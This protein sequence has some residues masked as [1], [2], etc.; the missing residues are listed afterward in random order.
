MTQNCSDCQSLYGAGNYEEVI[1]K[2]SIQQSKVGMEDLLLLAKS[3]HQLGNKKDA[4]DAYNYILTEDDKNV[5]ALIAVGALFIDLEKYDNAQ[6]AMERALKFEPKNKMANYNIAVI[7]FFKKENEKLQKFVEE[8]LKEDKNDAEFIYIKGV[9]EL[10]ANNFE[11]ALKHFEVLD[12]LDSKLENYTFY[13][14]YALMKSKDLEKAIEKFKSSIAK[15]DPQTV[16]SYYYLAQIYKE[17]ENKMEACEA[18]TNAIN[19]G[20]LTLR[21]EA[22]KYCNAKKAKNDKIKDRGVRLS[23]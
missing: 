14:A 15:N 2:I 12:K 22:D 5:E 19:L 3:H 10:Q 1:E 6:F 9:S 16:D 18:Y 20:D 11:G 4:I 23:F 21:K 7:Y 17:K 8:K 13:Q